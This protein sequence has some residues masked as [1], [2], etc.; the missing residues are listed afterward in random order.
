MVEGNDTDIYNYSRQL[1]CSQYYNYC[2]NEYI[3]VSPV[4]VVHIRGTYEGRTF[5]ER[6]VTFDFGEGLHTL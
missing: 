2:H 5:D 3:L 1:L 6:D 4:H